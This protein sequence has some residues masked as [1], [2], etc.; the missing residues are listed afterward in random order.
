MMN[1]PTSCA[2][3][4]RRICL[5]IFV[6]EHSRAQ[7]KDVLSRGA[8]RRQEVVSN[9]SRMRVQLTAVRS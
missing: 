8:G 6:E 4:M 7:M 2:V 1:P 5:R 9:V 3:S